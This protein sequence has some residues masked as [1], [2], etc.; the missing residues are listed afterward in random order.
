MHFIHTYIPHSLVSNSLGT[1]FGRT[2]YQRPPI[3]V[4]FVSNIAVFI[5]WAQDFDG[6]VWFFP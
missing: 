5:L 4:Y 1:L 3:T 2:Q 6:C